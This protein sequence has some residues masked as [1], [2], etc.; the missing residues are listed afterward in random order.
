MVHEFASIVHFN[1]LEYRQFS[2]GWRFNVVHYL[3]K[4]K[5]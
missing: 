5:C 4:N 1:G 2:D 3:I